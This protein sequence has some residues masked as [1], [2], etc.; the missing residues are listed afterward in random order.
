MLCAA[1]MTMSQPSVVPG[2]VSIIANNGDVSIFETSKISYVVTTTNVPIM[3]STAGV[4]GKT[5]IGIEIRGTKPGGGPRGWI[6]TVMEYAPLSSFSGK[7]EWAIPAEYAGFNYALRANLCFEKACDGSSNF[8]NSGTSQQFVIA[9]G[10]LPSNGNGTTSSTGTI[11]NGPN[12]DGSASKSAP[13]KSAAMIAGKVWA[14][15]VGAVA[16][17]AA[18]V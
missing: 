11:A 7:G 4:F 12:T 14:V 5:L 17:V 16:L 15:V 13:S 3:E 9:A 18:L 8:Q 1:V 2:S 10:S 6:A